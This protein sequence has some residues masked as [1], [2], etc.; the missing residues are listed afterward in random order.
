MFRTNLINKIP[1]VKGDLI[2]NA[3]LAKSSWFRVGGPAEVLFVPR[4]EVDLVKFIKELDPEIPL[5]VL[6]ATSNVLI[7]DG[8]IKG[9]VI[10]L[11]AN[12]NQITITKNN[13]KAGGAAMDMK[14]ASFAAKK[15]IGG[16]EFLSGIPG[17]IGGSV[18]MN[19]GAYGSD[20]SDILYRIKLLERNGKILEVGVSDLRMRYR[21]SSIPK[22]S[23]IVE[24]ELKGHKE[25][26]KVIFNK[27]KEINITRSSTQPIKNLTG[28][29]TFKNPPGFK[30]WQLID[31]AG[32]R[33]LSV[34]GAKISETHP[35]FIINEGKAMSSD[36]ENLG[37]E[38]QNR[39]MDH[40]GI[41]LKWEILRLGSK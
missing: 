39:V 34:G 13:I 1:K 27:I 5:L 9:V 15:G 33:G 21:N 22:Y 29:S 10:K 7:R 38:V 19:A 36:I 37:I 3:I 6:G 16:M 23:I 40:S 41:K 8:G 24:V 26:Q 18:K 4:D 14:I 11:G 20:I 25:N 2:T 30:A 35:N 17:S 31:Q 12:F 28:G 32:C